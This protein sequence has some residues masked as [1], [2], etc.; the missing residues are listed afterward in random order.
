MRSVVT[1][2][3]PGIC[4]DLNVAG[5]DVV[6]D[7]AGP[8]LRL[9]IWLQG[10]PRRCPGCAN[11]PYLPIRLAHRMKVADIGALLDEVPGCRGITLSGGEPVLQAEPLVPLLDDVHRRGLSTVCYTGHAREDLVGPVAEQFLVLVDLLID[12][13]YRRELPRGGVYR[14]SSNQRLHFLSGCIEPA[15]CLSVAETVVRVAR[16][17]TSMTGT[18]PPAVCRKVEEGLRNRGIVTKPFDEGPLGRFVGLSGR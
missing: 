3:Y 16:G 10:C 6:E 1:N 7:A 11:G 12:G 18:L 4:P 17:R 9:V 2:E 5:L 14:P 8:G 13:E 15:D